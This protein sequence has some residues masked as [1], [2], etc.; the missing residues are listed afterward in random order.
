[1]DLLFLNQSNSNTVLN[2]P[3]GRPLYHVD[4]PFQMFGRTTNIS[5]LDG[6]GGNSDVG[7]VELHGMSSDVVAVWGR[8]VTPQRQ[9]IFST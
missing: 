8:D 9:G 3:D 2:M 7:V 6:R 1:M 5:K 4:S